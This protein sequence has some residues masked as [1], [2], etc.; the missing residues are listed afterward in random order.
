MF[1]NLAKPTE[2]ITEHTQKCLEVAV[3]L[4]GIFKNELKKLDSTNVSGEELFFLSVIFHDFGKYAQPFQNKTL[5]QDY[6]GVWGYRHEIFSAEFVHLLDNLSIEEIQLIQLAILSH[7]NKSIDH[8]EK[9]CFQGNSNSQ[10]L[11]GLFLTDMN[12]NRKLAY[13]EGKDSILENWDNI[14]SEVERLIKNSPIPAHVSYDAKN[15]KNIFDLITDYYRAVTLYDRAFDYNKIIFL[16]GLLVTS[17]HLGSAGKKISIIDDDIEE[18]YIKKFGIPNEGSFRSIQKMCMETGGAT[19]ILKAPTGT[20]KTEAAFLWAG[21]NLRQNRYARIFYILPY[22]ASLNAMFARLNSSQF[23][24]DRVDILHGK[25][26][27]Y[28]FDLITKNKR[29]DEIGENAESINIEI[30]LRKGLAKSFAAPIKLCTPHQIIKN[31]YG[32]K[33]FEEALLQYYN[34]LF[35]FDEIHCYD[36]VFLAEL[37]SSMWKIK[38]EMNGKFLFMSATFPKIIED[39]IRDIMNIENATIQFPDRELQDFTRTRLSV[40]DGL[41]EES[42]NFK[43]I[44]ADIASGKRVLIICNTIKKAQ[45]I[46]MRINS[47]NKILLHSAFNTHDRKIIETKILKGEIGEENIQVLIGTQ[48]IEVSLDLDYDCCYSEIASIDALIQRFGRVYRNRKRNNNEYGTV[49]VFLEN[50]LASEKIYNEKIDNEL[51]NI[52]EKTRDLL[53]KLNRMPLSFQALCEGIDDIY[54]EK[55]KQSIQDLISSKI[56]LF[57][58][59]CLIPMKDYS[60]EAKTYFEQFDGIKV[61]PSKLYDKYEGL[62]TKKRYVEADSLLITLSERKLFNYYRQHCVSKMKIAGRDIFVAEQDYV[63]YDGKIGLRIIDESASPFL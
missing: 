44:Q 14:F 23:A 43:R 39:I 54:D 57:S 28:Y 31:F 53:Y 36:R 9:A 17:D 58:N 51:Y 37:L 6:K 48:A 47:E 16:K 50:D 19:S 30:R 10:L 8:L 7:H 4:G 41:I 5:N 21:Q 2:T 42:C 12:R 60:N 55:Y 22:T 32:L 15:L 56:A 3:Q 59:G 33:H 49:T 1:K 18:Y 63:A 29:D 45:D 13:D 38:N 27:A 34:G 61:L 46:S 26:T 25:N 52:I 24:Q 20:G 11:P 40:I 35:I 62:L